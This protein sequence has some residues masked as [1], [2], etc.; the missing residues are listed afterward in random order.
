MKEIPGTVRRNLDFLKSNN[1]SSDDLSLGHI[2][3]LYSLVPLA[4]ANRAPI[5]D[6][7][8]SGK[9]VGIGTAGKS[10][11]KLMSGLCDKLLNN[12]GAS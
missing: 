3:F 10:Y 7:G 1:L 2:P 5:H 8:R 4:Q 9:L 12:I 11:K 6:V